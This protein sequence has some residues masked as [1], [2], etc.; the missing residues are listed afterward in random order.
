MPEL[1]ALLVVL[2]VMVGIGLALRQRE[3]PGRKIW[4][5]AS[6]AV[7]AIGER[8]RGASGVLSGQG[9]SLSAPLQLAAGALR[10]D[11]Q[12]EGLTRLALVDASGEETLFI[13]AGQGSE[14]VEI[15]GAGAYRL[16]VEPGQETWTWEIAYRPIGS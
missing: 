11:Y 3:M 1:V 8:Q 7:V 12:F 5:D 13:K 2:L 6:G 10:I 16:L 4:R 9:S 14:S 15:G